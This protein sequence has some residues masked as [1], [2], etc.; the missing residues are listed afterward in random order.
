MWYETYD[1]RDDLRHDVLTG[2]SQA[3]EC[4]CFYDEPSAR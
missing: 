4:V 2:L 1:G 3:V